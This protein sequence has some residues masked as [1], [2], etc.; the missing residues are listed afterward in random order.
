LNQTKLKI[1]TCI[2]SNRIGLFIYIQ[3][4]IAIIL[5]N[6]QKKQIIIFVIKNITKTVKVQNKLLFTKTFSISKIN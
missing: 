5:G 6:V 1:Y 4:T 3:L 2:N